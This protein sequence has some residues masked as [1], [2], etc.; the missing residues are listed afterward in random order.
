MN[1]VSILFG[2]LLGILSGILSTFGYDKLKNITRRKNSK[3]E[4]LPNLRN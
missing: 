4:L 2:W 1:I 3:R